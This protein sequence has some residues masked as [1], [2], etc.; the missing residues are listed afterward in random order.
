MSF[1]R[2]KNMSKGK[3]VFF[4][5]DK[6][7]VIEENVQGPDK[8]SFFLEESLIL[9]DGETALDIVTGTGFHAIMVAEKASKVVGVDVNPISVR[10]AKLNVRLNDVEGVVDIRQGDLFDALI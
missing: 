7:F 6:I 8:Y 1:G 5:K 4:Y 10:C 3:H 2:G 9:R